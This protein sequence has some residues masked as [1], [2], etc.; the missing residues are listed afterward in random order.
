MIKLKVNFWSKLRIFG[1]KN[2][3]G[4]NDH[5]EVFKK[6]QIVLNEIKLIFY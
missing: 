3:L 4:E 1:S 2:I 5:P 6:Y